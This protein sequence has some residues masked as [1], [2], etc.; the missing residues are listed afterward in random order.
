[1]E[2]FAFFLNN[3]FFWKDFFA[4]YNTWQ[5]FA[6]GFAKDGEFHRLLSQNFLLGI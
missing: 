6:E 3:R 1:V 4:E 5:K 2:K